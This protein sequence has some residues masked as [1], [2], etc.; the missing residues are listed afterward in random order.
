MSEQNEPK[1]TE[2]ILALFKANLL[3][4]MLTFQ[5]KVT[6]LLRNSGLDDEIMNLVGERIKQLFDSISAEMKNT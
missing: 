6:Q 1:L 3:G 5:N 4:T 2:P